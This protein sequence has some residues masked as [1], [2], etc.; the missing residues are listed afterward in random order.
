M[1]PD[2][3]IWDVVNQ[4]KSKGSKAR[5]YLAELN[6]SEQ[7]KPKGSD[8]EVDDY[9]GYTLLEK[10]IL[11]V[12]DGAKSDGPTIE[13]LAFERDPTVNN[14]SSI[15]IP[16]ERLTPD[17][18]CK[19]IAIQCQIFGAA[20]QLRQNQTAAFARERPAR[21]DTGFV[22]QL[23]QET[24]E[25]IEHSSAT[26]EEK[27][28]QKANWQKRIKA[29]SK[30]LMTCGHSGRYKM[31]APEG[32]GYVTSY[33][34]KMTFPQFISQITRNALVVGRIAVEVIN[35]QTNEGPKFF[36]FR[37]VDA[38]TIYQARPQIY[39]ETEDVKKRIRNI[40]GTLGSRRL[41][42]NRFMED[43]YAWV[44][45]V[46]GVPQQAFTPEEL[47]VHNFYAVP[48]I[49]L[50]GYPVTPIDMA[51]VSIITHINVS[52]Y[53]KL[54]FE[55]GKGSKGL[56]VIKSEDVDEKYVDKVKQVFNSQVN[57]VQN[58]WRM[59]VFGITPED[60]IQWQPIEGGGGKDMEFQYLNDMTARMILSA[61]SMDPEE[62]S[63]WRYLS[64][65][66]ASQSLSEG[67]NEYRLEAARDTGIRP[68]LSQL[69]NFVNEEL[70]P[71]IDPGLAEAAIFKFVGLEAETAEKES[72]RLQTD[73]QLHLT[74]DEM[75]EKVEKRP[76]GKK[77]G[78]E[79]P[80]NPVYQ[81][82]V[83]YKLFTIGQILE[84]FCGIEGAS[85]DPT[86][87]YIPDQSWFQ[88]QQIL[89]AQQQAQQQAQMA[90]QQQAMGQP[91]PNQ[92]AGAPP[93][94]QGPL[95]Q[96]GQ[97]VPTENQ[98]TS[99][100]DE[101]GDPDLE[102]SINQAVDS[103]KKADPVRREKLLKQQKAAIA[104]A[105]EGM[106]VDAHQALA[107]I[108]DMMGKGAKR[109]KKSN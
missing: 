99:Q 64:R 57:S 78:G 104:Q 63:G 70:L 43:E 44:Q 34:Q 5:P 101:A 28:T 40:L 9:E 14:Y 91:A 23:S 87:A 76:I 100:E 103:L 56:L 86:L 32:N 96:D 6:K 66:T 54:Y 97:G 31:L 79:M 71:L 38:G 51:L 46:E 89:Q 36:C 11:Q 60:D 4:T 7:K 84:H 21:S 81:N 12:I 26:D 22:I 2:N 13:R 8:R 61:L 93:N 58:S 69:E 107:E 33:Q 98:R 80:L 53:T 47:R 59:P 77:W 105:M 67:N 19:R 1:K 35:Q 27:R 17:W 92:Q 18:L 65:G 48:D 88:W 73:I 20:V 42:P 55:S 62:V 106:A 39:S 3:S 74:M 90:Q 85:K 95:G 52:T 82:T 94:A 10:S 108:M 72:E 68:L 25:K 15:Y 37:P 41:D 102:S 45:V 109:A 75:L 50:N 16:K 29:A 83:L 24:T 30:L 49:E